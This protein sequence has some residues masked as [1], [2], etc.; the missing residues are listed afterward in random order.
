VTGRAAAL[1]AA[2]TILFTAAPEAGAEQR[3]IRVDVESGV[4]TTLA[5]AAEGEVA[6][7]RPLAVRPDGSMILHVYRDGPEFLEERAADGTLLGARRR[8]DTHH[9]EQMSPDLRSVAF[10]DTARERWYASV[11]RPDGSQRRRVAWAR[12]GRMIEAGWAGDRLVVARDTETATDVM[13]LSRRWTVA[14]HAR[15]PGPLYGSRIAG[16]PDGAHTALSILTR[17]P[18]ATRLA[19]VDHAS[20]R[21]RVLPVRGT[22]AAWS[23]DSRSLASYE[24]ARGVWLVDAD[25][26][27]ARLAASRVS[28]DAIAWNPDGSRIA[29]SRGSTRRGRST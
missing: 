25:T 3:L 17:G 9:F 4:V 1:A 6:H 18:G 23:R 27:R 20:R 13:V 26:G 28:V 11:A 7:W 2:L 5:A 19:V 21:C 29:V 14:R 10:F 15:C 24:V 22:D 8:R 16:S 12:A